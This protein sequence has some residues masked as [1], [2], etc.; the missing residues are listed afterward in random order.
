MI[1]PVSFTPTPAIKELLEGLVET[2]LWGSTPGECVRRIVEQFLWKEIE[3]P[4]LRLPKR[5]T[6]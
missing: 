1:K 5:R 2:G 6:R 4:I 3:R